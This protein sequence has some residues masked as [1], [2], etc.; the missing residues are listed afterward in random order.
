MVNVTIDDTFTRSSDGQVSLDYAGSWESV[1]M[2]TQ[3]DLAEKDNLD[4]YY[5]RTV[6][7]TKERGAS[8]AFTG[9]GKLS[10][11]SHSSQLTARVG[12]IPLRKRWSRLWIS[13]RVYQRPGGRV[14]DQS[15]C[16]EDI[17]LSFTVGR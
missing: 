2:G 12:S 13:H 4:G 7:I 5:N 1:K 9:A 6:A 3:T 16:E 15:H 11:S 14:I 8:V 17:S 10:K